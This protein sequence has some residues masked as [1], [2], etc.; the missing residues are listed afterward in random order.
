MFTKTSASA[1]IATAAAIA[2]A[3]AADSAVASDHKVTVALHVS[4]QGLDLSQPADART[5]YT[6]LENAAWIACTRGNRAD[7]VPV[8]NPKRCYE[9]SLGSAVRTARQPLLT[10]IYLGTHTLQEAALQGIDTRVLA[11]K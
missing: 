3:L 2:G 1:F 4:T 7:L 6:R 9:D 10:Q 5:F 11:S 8:D